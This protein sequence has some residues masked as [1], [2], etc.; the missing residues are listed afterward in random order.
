M[1]ET[2]LAVSGNQGRWTTDNLVFGTEYFF[3]LDNGP[4]GRNTA[5]TRGTDLQYRGGPGRRSVMLPIDM[6]LRADNRLRNIVR[7]FSRDRAA[8]ETHFVAAWRQIQEN[9]F[10]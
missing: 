8:Y 4:W 7:Q 9:G 10:Q 5:E 1:G 3:N 2:H 6:A